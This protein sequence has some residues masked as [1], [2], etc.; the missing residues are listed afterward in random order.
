[1]S[2]FLSSN[3][4]QKTK[5]NCLFNASLWLIT[6]GVLT[7]CA[8]AHQGDKFVNDKNVV[9]ACLV[10]SRKL[11]TVVNATENCPE[12][13]P[14]HWNITGAKGDRGI[15]GVAGKAGINGKNGI[16][17]RN[18]LNGKDGN[19]Q[20]CN[21]LLPGQNLVA[22]DFAGDTLS[23]ADLRGSNLA[24]ANLTGAKLNPSDNAIT[25]L[26]GSNF[27]SAILTGANLTAVT[28]IG[29]NFAGAKL[30]RAIMSRANLQNA[31][32]TGADLRN[33]NLTGADLTGANLY[34]AKLSVPASGVTA[35]TVLTN[36]KW[37]NTVCPDGI[38]SNLLGLLPNT[39]RFATCADG[40]LSCVLPQPS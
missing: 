30:D 7:P 15:T 34:C 27:V 37:D 36:V 24:W 17:G 4:S 13:T 39:T 21:L 19:V 11:V 28:A 32:L 12:G 18:G 9:H 25:K 1:M 8:Y 40:H 16:P 26:D 6:A 5:R 31:N 22:C 33:A 2:H 23:G 3:K 38:P 29:V 35:A 10:G 20:D 14:M